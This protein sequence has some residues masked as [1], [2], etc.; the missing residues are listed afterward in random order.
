MTAKIGKKKV[1]CKIHVGVTK[2]TATKK[3]DVAIGE[4][5]N[6]YKVGDK[7]TFY[8]EEYEIVGIIDAD[9]Y[10][11][12]DNEG[13]IFFQFINFSPF[14]IMLRKGDIIGQG[15]IKP[16]LTADNDETTKVR[17]GGFGSTG[18]G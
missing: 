14:P 17:T 12:P 15:I 4:T 8:G 9:F 18:N 11:N 2:L 13:E 7:C 1:K 3:L 16:Y 5:G 10:N 6:I